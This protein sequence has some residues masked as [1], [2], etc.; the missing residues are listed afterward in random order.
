MKKKFQ[1]KEKK[2]KKKRRISEIIWRN[3]SVGIKRRKDDI[4]PIVVWHNYALLLKVKKYWF[5]LLSK[6]VVYDKSL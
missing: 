2:K 6:P 1:V 3:I 5:S 4:A